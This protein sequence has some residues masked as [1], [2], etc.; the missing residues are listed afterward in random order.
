MK[1]V[2][3]VI[4]ILANSNL[5]AQYFGSN[6]IGFHQGIII[7]NQAIL[8]NRNNA[9]NKISFISELDKNWKL[10]KKTS[11]HSGLGFGN[12]QNPDNRFE[13]YQST[14]F[15]RLKMGLMFHLPQILTPRK[16]APNLLNPFFKVAYNFDILDRN[17]RAIGKQ[18]INSN[19]RLSIGNTVRINHFLGIYTEASLNQRVNIDY[20]T[21]FQ[22]NI[23]LIINLDPPLYQ[24]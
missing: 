2:L 18:K 15:F 20:R 21:F 11:F 14:N 22:Y 8:D 3:I 9:N 6:H 24:Y 23:G 4:L 10:G 13:A 19:L 7:F 17:F 16:Q 1:K 12:Y 5:K